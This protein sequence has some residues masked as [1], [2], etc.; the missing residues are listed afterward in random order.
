MLF[1]IIENKFIIGFIFLMLIIL[2]SFNI[3]GFINLKSKVKETLSY[4]SKNE[5]IKST[6]VT[7]VM[8]KG[9]EANKKLLT[10]SRLEKYGFLFHREDPKTSFTKD[11]VIYMLDLIERCEE[12]NPIL[13]MDLLIGIIWTNSEFDR[14]AYNKRKN[15][16]GLS[17][18]TK[19]E[20]IAYEKD[21]PYFI[22]KEGI[23]AYDIIDIH[24]HR[25]IDDL[26]SCI[27]VLHRENKPINTQ[28][29]VLEYY[30][31]NKTAYIKT[32]AFLW[33]V[34]GVDIGQ[35]K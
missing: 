34:R 11:E 35:Y 14:T 29:L 28:N 3:F 20:L 15:T 2:A 30:K 24:I 6:T 9:L 4:E 8:E 25:I 12:A 18:K 27:M 1:T 32:R 33:K 5:F 7:E 26:I 31:Y 16:Y 22:S 17:Q 21:K 13:T 23:E 19:D 10:Q